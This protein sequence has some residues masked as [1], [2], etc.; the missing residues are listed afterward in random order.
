MDFI[1]SVVFIGQWDLSSHLSSVAPFVLIQIRPGSSFFLA[2]HDFSVCG[3]Y[4]LSADCN[5]TDS[6]L[7][8]VLLDRCCE[9][10]FSLQIYPHH[11]K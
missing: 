8:L 10:A 9:E 7:F 5:W 3:I 11:R 6:S 1:G 4:L 2:F